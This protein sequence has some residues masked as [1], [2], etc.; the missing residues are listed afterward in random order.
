MTRQETS[1]TTMTAATPPDDA[2]KPRVAGLAWNAWRQHRL[3]ITGL[4]A[5]FACY[6]AWLLRTGIPVHA[7]YVQYL[8]RGCPRGPGCGRLSLADGY[9]EVVTGPLTVLPA[10]IGVFVGAPL[11]DRDLEAGPHRFAMTQGVRMHRQ[12]AVR[13]LVVGGIAVVGC[14]LVGLLAMWCAQPSFATDPLDTSRWDPFFFNRTAVMLPAWALLEFC[15]GALAGAVIRRTVPAMAVTAACAVVIA[16]AGTGMNLSFPF[17]SPLP[18][19]TGR[20]LS[21]APISAPVS[22]PLP[23]VEVGGSATNWA[24]PGGTWVL[25]TWYTGPDGRR[26]SD[27]AAWTLVNRIGGNAPAA[28]IW[29]RLAARHVAYWLSYQPASRYWLFQ[30]AQAAILAAL[31]AAAG[32]GAVRLAGRRT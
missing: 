5:V 30:A 6:A 13:L 22:R 12:V 27:G 29:R 2:R 31:A 4:L 14:V 8:L 9:Y 24:G 15:L 7:A 18:A 16:V 19:L 11:I 23:F 25:T 3:A 32:L 26:L 28:V 1:V 17:S 10:L 21:I 20:L